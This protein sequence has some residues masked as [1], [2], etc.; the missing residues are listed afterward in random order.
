MW[1]DKVSN[2]NPT[3][4]EKTFTYYESKDGTMVPLTY[5]H[6][7]DLEIN[8]ETPIFLYGY[9]GYNISIRPSFSRKYV[10]WLELGGV[11]AIANLRGGGELGKK[12]HNAGR[13][14]EKQNVFDD[15]LYASKYLEANNIGNRKSTVISGRSNGGLLVGTSLVQNPNY[16]GATLPLDLFV[17]VFLGLS[18]AIKSLI[19]KPLSRTNLRNFSAAAWARL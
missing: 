4:Y 15:F 7:K 9:G 8:T 18:A 2:F 12:W 11:V 14:K 3:D 1:Q 13:L 10:G 19:S 17:L 5:F 6:R 16:F